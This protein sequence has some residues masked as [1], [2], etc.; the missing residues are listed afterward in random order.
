MSGPSQSPSVAPSV[1][2]GDEDS[3]DEWLQFFEA[4][5]ENVDKIDKLGHISDKD[6]LDINSLKGVG[7]KLSKYYAREAMTLSNIVKTQVILDALLTKYAARITLLTI[8]G[9]DRGRS[10]W[11]VQSGRGRKRKVAFAS[12]TPEIDPKR[13]RGTYT[14]QPGKLQCDEKHPGAPCPP[15]PPA[16]TGTMTNDIVRALVFGGIFIGMAYLI[17][18]ETDYARPRV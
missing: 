16:K 14:Y 11:P 7:E 18:E 5:V 10:E 2:Q 4:T 3:M 9:A 6:L 12:P 17:K 15:V 8:S 13:T 1:V